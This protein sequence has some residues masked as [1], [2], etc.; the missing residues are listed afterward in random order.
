MKC[1]ACGAEVPAGSTFCSKCGAQLAGSTATAN[2]VRATA[3]RL[4]PSADRG[5]GAQPTEDELWSG[6]YSP[7]AMIGWIVGAALVSVMA[8]VVAAIAGAAA[9]A[10]ILIVIGL[11]ILWA[12]LGLVA[13]YQRLSVRYQLTTYR[14][15]HERGLLSRTRDRIEVI[16]IDDVTLR[17][18]LIERMLNVGTIH[19]QSSDT[20][21]GNLQMAGIDDAR[22]VTDLIDNTRRAERQRR[23]IFMENV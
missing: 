10:W 13:L 3:A 21:H 9:S 4:Q 15:F 20:T 12:I 14:L 16:D 6:S 7:K 5:T 8:V 11:L 18:G 19:I 22:R 23:G 2:P 1:N 17:Q